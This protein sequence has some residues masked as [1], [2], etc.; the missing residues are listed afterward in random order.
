[1]RTLARLILVS[2]VFSSMALLVAQAQGDAGAI[3]VSTYADVNGN[4]MRDE[5]ETGLAGVNVN[6]STGG[7]IVATHIT[8]EGEAEYCF[9]GL[10]AGIYTVAFTD[11]PTYRTTTASE[12]TYA[13]AA[14]QIL[15]LNPF[16]AAPIPAD[17]W[18][19]EVAARIAAAQDEDEPLETSVRLLVSTVAS[20]VVMIFMIG[21]GAVLLGIISGG[22]RRSSSR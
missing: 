11:S 15:T 6:L 9:E 14:G 1:M 17:Q 2:A 5:G 16:G 22:N 4:G 3:C 8:E 21:V 13:I 12:G 18:R 7:V 19:A 20:M 10:A